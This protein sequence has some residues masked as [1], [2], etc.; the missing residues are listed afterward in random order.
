MPDT[1][2]TL[3]D[4]GWPVTRDQLLDAGCLFGVDAV[5][6]RRD[7]TEFKRRARWH[8][9][10]WR[11]AQDLP[12]GTHRPIEE[13][14]PNGSRIPLDLAK[15]TGANFL[16]DAIRSQVQHRLDHHES[17][18]TLDENR[19]WSDLLSSMPMCFNLFGEAA[20]NPA[21][22]EA[23]VDALWPTHP[24]T[25]I[26]LRFEW[27]PGRRDRTYLSNRTAFDAAVILDLDHEQLGVI[28][29]ETKYHEHIKHERAPSDTKRMPRYRE[30]TERSGVFA[31]GWEEALAGTDLQQIWLDHLLVLAML[32]H[33]SGRWAWGRYVLAYP[34]ANPSVRDAAARYREVL[35]DDT[36][37][38][39]RTIEELLEP[40]VLHSPTT[41][42][43]FRDRYL[44]DL[45]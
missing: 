2:G 39:V 25:A 11:I 38:E 17:H 36:T 7:V 16:S 18:Q 21:H 3:G 12:I 30:V 27:S 24:G 6:G 45:T 35:T 31:T 41:A 1:H 8:Q 34:A 33:P 40:G 19:L 20:A 15:E 4:D 43:T 10:Q 44:W 32:Q 37:F 14:R 26:E 42:M 5:R 13:Q 23:A 28:G 9:S 29:I 22:L